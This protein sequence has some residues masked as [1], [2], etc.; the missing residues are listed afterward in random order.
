MVRFKQ[1]CKKA[2]GVRSVF[3]DGVPVMEE[4]QQAARSTKAQW[5]S[6]LVDLAAKNGT[7]ALKFRTAWGAL[8]NMF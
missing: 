1:H 8:T 3:Q 5:R 4:P 6:F 7:S 2:G